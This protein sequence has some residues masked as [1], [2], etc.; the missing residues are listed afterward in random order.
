MVIFVLYIMRNIYNYK[1]DLIF[2][3]KMCLK[4]IFAHFTAL[5][6]RD[7][8]GKVGRNFLYILTFALETSA[9]PNK[10]CLSFSQETAFA[11]KFF[12]LPQYIC[13]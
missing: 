13:V 10:L 8:D 9:F 2:L 12:E 7:G 5:I 1:T 3:S 6:K 11:H 4:L